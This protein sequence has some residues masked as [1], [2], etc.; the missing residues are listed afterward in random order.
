MGT[1]VYNLDGNKD[2]GVLLGFEEWAVQIPGR[3]RFP[4]PL[5]CSW[6]GPR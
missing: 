3:R 4:N 1:L 6:W 2:D 5:R